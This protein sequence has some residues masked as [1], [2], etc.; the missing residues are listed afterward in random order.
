MRLKSHLRVLPLIKNENAKGEALACSPRS[1]VSE[2]P[3]P[4]PIQTLTVGPGLTPDPAPP[5]IGRARGLPHK[6]PAGFTADRDFHP[7]PKAIFFC[8][9][10]YIRA[11]FVMQISRALLCYTQ[12]GDLFEGFEAPPLGRYAQRGYGNPE[13]VKAED[14]F[15]EW[16]GA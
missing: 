11:N 3:S 8:N 10:N 4:S 9:K 13:S 16:A 7:A 6:K 2:T 15:G 14:G 5:N 1:T 12:E